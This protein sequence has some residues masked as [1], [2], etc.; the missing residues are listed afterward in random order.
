MVPCHRVRLLAINMPTWHH[1]TCADDALMGTT[2]GF[3]RKIKGLTMPGI[4]NVDG[5]P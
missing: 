1:G 2:Y 5:S 3:L 4:M